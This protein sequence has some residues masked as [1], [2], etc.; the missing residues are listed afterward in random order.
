MLWIIQKNLTAMY[1]G[2]VRILESNCVQRD[3]TDSPE[4]VKSCILRNAKN[5]P[6]KLDSCLQWNA[7]D[8]LEEVDVCV[9]GNATE[10]T[11][12]HDSFIQQF[13]GDDDG[14]Y[15]SDSNVSDYFRINDVQGFTDQ[16]VLLGHIITKQE[17]G[18]AFIQ[19]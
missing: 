17:N 10:S 5:F 2:M 15:F 3:V 12:K 1:L 9:A 4:K 11:E 7:T 18:P 13:F 6:E 19:L 16:M 8:S 14:F